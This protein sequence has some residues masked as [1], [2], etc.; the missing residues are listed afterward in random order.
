MRSTVDL[1][2]L[3]LLLEHPSYGYELCK[4]YERRFDQL[5][6]VSRSHVYSALNSLQRDGLIEP[7]PADDSG[8][9]PKVRYRPTAAGAALFRD[10]VSEQL[11]ETVRRSRLLGQLAAIGVGRRDEV[12]ELVDGHEHAVAAALAALDGDG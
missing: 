9:Q 12:L 6:R 5:A 10:E 4:R 1:V 7:L 11:D 2:V 8:R 3:G